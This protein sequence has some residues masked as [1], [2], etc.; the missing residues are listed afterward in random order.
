MSDRV[1]LGFG[2]KAR[3]YLKAWL[4]FGGFEVPGIFFFSL[5]KE[6]GQDGI[7]QSVSVSYNYGHEGS[8]AF[9]AWMASCVT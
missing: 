5:G 6:G 8:L 2:L 4:F 3:L 9:A 7:E 1:L